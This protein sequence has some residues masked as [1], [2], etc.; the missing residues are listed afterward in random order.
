MVGLLCAAGP[1]VA[2][3]LEPSRT[4]AAVPATAT[5]EELQRR[6]TVGETPYVLD[7]AGQ[8]TRGFSRT[9]G[10]TDIGRIERQRKDSV[11]NGVLI[12]A[13]TGALA[14]Y[15]LGKSMD[16][17]NCSGAVECGQGAIVGAVGGAVWG[18]VGGWLVDVLIRKRETIHLPPGSK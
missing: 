1:L 7:L 9:V 16:S 6:A 15:G 18:A 12:G 2:Q 3:P 10:A 13:G 14:G 11:L 17:P 8:E 4:P 5:F